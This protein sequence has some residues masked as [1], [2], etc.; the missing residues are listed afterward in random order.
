MDDGFDDQRNAVAAAVDSRPWQKDEPEELR[1]PNREE[2]RRAKYL[3]RR[4][5]V[6]RPGADAVL[7]TRQPNTRVVA[8]FEVDAASG[9][10]IRVVDHKA[11]S[12]PPW[13]RRQRRRAANRV[14]RRSRKA[15]RG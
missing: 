7:V 14:A 15:N 3:T 13:A 9:Q 11:T 5:V 1:E 8:A 4:T 12:V 10:E 6:T 2:R